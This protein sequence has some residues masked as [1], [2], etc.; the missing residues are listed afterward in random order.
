[1]R[2]ITCIV[3]PRGCTITVAL[4]GTHI[5]EMQGA[6]CKKGEAYATQECFDPRRNIATS[7][8]VLNGILP[9]ASV[10]LTG[11]IPKAR[12]MDVMAVIKTIE[13]EA[14]VKA[15]DK[16]IRDVLGLG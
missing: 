16:V 7:I 3:C 11:M 2:T 8:K 1:M 12:I 9:L 14:P 6:G 5:T 4:E 15:G 10:R 13:V